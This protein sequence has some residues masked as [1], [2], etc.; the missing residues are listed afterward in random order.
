[1]SEKPSRSAVRVLTILSLIEGAVIQ[2][3]RQADPLNFNRVQY[4]QQCCQ[5][6]VN[7]W[8]VV[9]DESPAVK[10]VMVQLKKISAGLDG[11]WWLKGKPD[12]TLPGMLYVSLQLVDDLLSIITHEKRR[13]WLQDIIDGLTI[14]IDKIDPEGVM[15]LT[16]ERAS[17]IVNVIYTAVGEK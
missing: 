6:A 12:M 10:A 15:F 11:L 9:G 17:E 3:G 16:Q 7:G 2:A 14:L 1:M 5:T 4:V 8:V 13:L